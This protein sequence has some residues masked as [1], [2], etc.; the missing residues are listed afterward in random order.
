MRPEELPVDYVVRRRD[1]IRVAR[2]WVGAP[3]R[4]QGRGRRG[5]DCVGLLIE[6]AKGVGHPV[7]APSAYSNMPQGHQL[8]VPC[9]AQLWKP[10]RQTVI[11]GDLAVF[12]GWN[13]AEPQHFAFIAELGGRLTLIHS[14]SKYGKV[15]EHGWNKLWGR[16]FHCLYNLPGTEE[17]Y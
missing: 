15:V 8:L 16:K 5:I 17:S 6:V 14:F 3:Y 4:H 12:W 1:I 13:R 2:D 11:P 9:D 7:D 10:K